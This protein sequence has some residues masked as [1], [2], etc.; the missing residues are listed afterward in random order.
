[1][2]RRVYPQKM[3]CVIAGEQAASGPSARER[4]SAADVN[5]PAALGAAVSAAR[6]PWCRSRL[7]GAAAQRAARRSWYWPAGWRTPMGS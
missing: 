2:Y 7:E 6:T 4:C 3:G 5:L 1:M